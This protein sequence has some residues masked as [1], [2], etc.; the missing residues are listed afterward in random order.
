M[1]KDV[2][3]TFD[4]EMSELK[5]SIDDLTGYMQGWGSKIKAI[6]I[7]AFG[8]F[9]VS[10][11]IGFAKDFIAEA[12]EGAAVHAKLE[13]V[14]KATGG[15]AGFTADEMS[16]MAKELRLITQVDDDVIKGAQTVLAT[17]KEVR[18][19]EFK[20]T[21]QA[22][23]DMAAV[24]GGDAQSAAMQL[25]KALN[26]PEKGMQM[27]AKAG[28][29][30]SESQQ[31]AIK[32]MVEAGD[33]AGAQNAIL[34]EMEA[35]FGGAAKAAADSTGPWTEFKFII[36]DVR[37]LMGNALLAAM[38]PIM[39]LLESG[40]ELVSDWASSFDEI[41]PSVTAFVEDG[42]Q[43]A[44]GAFEVLYD[45]GSAVLTGIGE[46]WVTVFGETATDS[47]GRVFDFVK[48]VFMGMLE[49]GVGFFTSIQVGWQQLPAVA[50]FAW[51]AIKLGAVS[52][53]EDLKHLF[54]V[55][56][57]EVL[58]WFFDNWRDI[59]T[60]IF[61]FTKTIFSNIW[62]NISNIFTAIVNW[63]F[64]GFKWTPLTEGFESAIK[65]LP[66]IAGREMTAL[67]KELTEKTGQ[68]GAALATKFQEKFK[69]NMAAL[70]FGDDVKTPEA[71]AA[72]AADASK[73][74]EAAKRD[75]PAR[76]E[77]GGDEKEKEAKA[78][79]EDF[80]S[81]FKRISAS[82]ASG[83]SPELKEAKKTADAT[84]AT[85]QNTHESKEKLSKIESHLQRIADK[86]A[87][88]G[89]VA[90]LGP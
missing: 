47:A 87:M 25:G 56:I 13:A 39:P 24:L 44:T 6:G 8:A 90:V 76:A 18:G 36:N 51:N 79:F 57:P 55:T 35:Q 66:N 38:K 50:E 89:G 37:E 11:A 33:V 43:F 77:R 2:S 27:L 21:T 7:A 78:S 58:R 65:E 68:Q 4:G 26:D 61:E 67:E 60:D 63:D 19:D 80:N 81:L 62:E 84:E 49:F 23:L 48:D 5:S 28:V 42:I 3:I 29:T 20:R 31:K 1:A 41:L 85:K 22:A 45:T 16:D 86:G 53:F 14:I 71:A 32:A 15:A 10:Q 54:T 64:S 83:G 17:F 88:G 75:A 40:A 74:A 46:L 34:A 52:T 69:A 12:N 70:G 72:V 9:G 30:F 82:A 59:F 73:A